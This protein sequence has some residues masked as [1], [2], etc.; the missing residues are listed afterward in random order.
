MQFFASI[1]RL[2]AALGI[3]FFLGKLAPDIFAAF[4]HN[5]EGE[6]IFIL[7][8][9][10]IICLLSFVIFYLSQGIGLP[11]FVV[12]IF[13][14]MAGQ[15]LLDSIVEDHALLGA[16]VGM[17]AAL[18]LFGGGIETPFSNFKKLFWRITSLSFVGL[19]LTSILFSLTAFYGSKLIGTPLSV[20]VA[21]LLGAILCSTDPASIV[22]VLKTLKFRHRDTK[23]IVVSES[24]LTDVTGTLLT[25]A[26]LSLLLG[27]AEWTGIMDGYGDLLSKETFV[28]L[29]K[30]LTYGAIFGV[31]GYF[32]L[33]A[34]LHFKKDHDQEFEADAAFFI[35]VPIIMFSVALVFGGSGYLAAFIAGLLFKLTEDLHHTERFFNHTIDG[36]LKPLIF[37][38][39]GAM[40]NLESLLSYLPLGLLVS[41]IFMFVIRP[42]AVFASFIPFLWQKDR[43]SIKELL[44]ISFVRETGAIPAVLLVAAVSAGLSDVE[45]LVPVG[46]WVILSTLIIQPPL[47]A[48][49]AKKLGVATSIETNK[50]PIVS[51]GNS[52]V[53]LGSRGGSFKNRLPLVIEWAEKHGIKR[54]VLLHCME[55]K[56]TEEKSMQFQE[57]ALKT[58]NE[59][60]AENIHFEFLSN[61]GFLQD[62]IQKLAQKDPSL[63]VVF[64]GQSIIDFRDKEI[65][66]LGVPL[67]FME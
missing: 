9:V 36:F 43:M 46:M 24:A 17:G 57:M 26:F 20:S 13:F 67:Y 5:P 4:E 44:F 56:H 37:L 29:A 19:G 31:L 6:L 64:V 8:E 32:F 51:S 47:T 33:E 38:L 45:G 49:V 15:P 35:F 21:I 28:F 11:S 39:L 52:Y 3:T 50:D 25:V 59:L 23:D 63:A 16:L 12:A 42:L 1:L 14:G 22:P 65:K 30:S 60:K 48:F 62:N 7:S 54:V 34:L 58:F 53:I 10:G 41:F 27:G 61:P 55:D 18:I 2:I 40:V 66:N